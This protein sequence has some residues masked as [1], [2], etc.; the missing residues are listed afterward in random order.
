MGT[1]QHTI[2]AGSTFRQELISKLAKRKN[3]RLYA[4]MGRPKIGGMDVLYAISGARIGLSISASEPVRL[5]DSDRLIRFLSCGT[6][7][8]ARR[9]PD[10]EL[11]FE[12]GEHLRYFDSIEE[13]FELADWY[14]KHEQERKRIADA[15]MNRAHQQFN[16][17]IIAGYFLE[18]VEKGSYN[19][20]WF[21]YLSTAKMNR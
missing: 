19:A 9:F 15:G 14:L 2:N 1:L 18:L 8:L 5:Y 6:F 20:P 3:C 12:D 21:K 17:T 13:F 7:V 11:L 16:G 4:C 10:C